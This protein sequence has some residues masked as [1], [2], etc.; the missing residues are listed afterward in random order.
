MAP[1]YDQPLDTNGILLEKGM[2]V[3]STDRYSKLRKLE[4]QVTGIGKMDGN[5]IPN[6]IT[7]EVGRNEFATSFAFM[8]EKVTE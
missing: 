7:V 5:D 6:A 4:G 3:R 8:W 2:A 1:E